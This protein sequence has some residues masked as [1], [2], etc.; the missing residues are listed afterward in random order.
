MDFWNSLAG[1]W[2]A[3]CT[4][5]AEGLGSIPGQGTKIPQDVHYIK[6][7]KNKKLF[8]K[9]Q[10]WIFTLSTAWQEYTIFLVH[11]GLTYSQQGHSEKD[12]GMGRNR[13][14]VFLTQCVLDLFQDKEDEAS[15]SPWKHVRCV[16][17]KTCTPGKSQLDWFKLKQAHFQENGHPIRYVH[18]F[19]PPINNCEHWFWP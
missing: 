19:V 2:L 5:S 17:K 4:F 12:W 11:L 18:S 8:L 10:R 14:Q 15:V 6:K 3:L 13:S 1:Q 16:Q 7:K 9:K